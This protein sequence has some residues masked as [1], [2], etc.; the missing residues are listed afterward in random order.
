MNE[1]VPWK[2][3]INTHNFLTHSLSY[4]LSYVIFYN[5]HLIV[6]NFR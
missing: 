2:I 4:I 6:H 5:K 3:A 1:K